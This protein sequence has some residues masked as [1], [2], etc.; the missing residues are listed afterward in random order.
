[1]YLQEKVQYYD[2]A[3]EK[4]AEFDRAMSEYNKKI[5]SNHHFLGCELTL[6]WPVM[7]MQ[8]IF[9][10]YMAGKWRV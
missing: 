6:I 1:L 5:V 10:Y 2:V 8:F 7:S 3:T 9:Y 4:R